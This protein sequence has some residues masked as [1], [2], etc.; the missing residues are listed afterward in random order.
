MIFLPNLKNM[1]KG[2][3]PQL[4]FTHTYSPTRVR[5]HTYSPTGAGAGVDKN[6]KLVLELKKNYSKS[7]FFSKFS[8]KYSEFREKIK[9]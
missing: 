6:T 3:L 8:R 7:Q 4:L 9:I 2:Y 1:L 5:I